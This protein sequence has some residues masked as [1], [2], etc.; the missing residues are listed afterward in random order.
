V[1]L[2]GSC[3]SSKSRSDISVRSV[4]GWGRYKGRKEGGT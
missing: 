4:L 3:S 2:S 1:G